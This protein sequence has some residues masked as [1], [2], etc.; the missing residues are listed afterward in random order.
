MISL[1]KRVLA[2]RHRIAFHLYMGHR[3]SRGPHHGRE[4]GGLVFL[5][6]SRRCPKAGKRAGRPGDSHRFCGRPAKR[7]P[8]PRQPR[9][10]WRPRRRWPLPRSPPKSPPSGM[11][12][13]S[14]WPPLTQQGAAEERFA[15]IRAH[16]DTLIANIN[17][18]EL[19]VSKR[20]ELN[21]HSRALVQQ[22]RITAKRTDRHLG[23]G[24]RRS[25][26]S[27]P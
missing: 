18:I 27:T 24:H 25:A 6:P 8:S 1:L 21:T 13:K 4:F 7:Y 3:H 12:L 5:R 11:P 10:W 17:A 2:A 23:S 15:R 14:N 19:S 22:S 9:A 26:I 16:G 20:F